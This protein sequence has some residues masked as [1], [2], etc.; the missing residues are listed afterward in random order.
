LPPHAIVLHS[1]GR[2][3]YF[4]L[5]NQL[6]AKYQPLDAIKGRIVRNIAAA[7]WRVELIHQLATAFWARPILERHQDG[8]HSFPE[9]GELY[10]LVSVVEHLTDRPAVDRLVRNFRKQQD[11]IIF[12]KEKRLLRIIKNFACPKA[13]I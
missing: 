5:E 3:T 12:A 2:H 13:T 7:E 6:I 1:K 10:T 4:R 11:R 8:N 9:I